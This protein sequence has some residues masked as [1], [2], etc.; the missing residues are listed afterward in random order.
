MQ[1]VKMLV[2]SLIFMSFTNPILAAPPFQILQTCMNG[3]PYNN[4]IVINELDGEGLAERSMD[5]CKDQYHRIFNGH[6]FGTLKCNQKFYLVINDKKINPELAENMSINPEIKPGTF[7]TP[8]ALWYKID[9]EEQSYLC[10]FAPIAEQGVGASYNQYYIIENA[11]N[12]D[13]KPKLYFYFLDKNITPITSK[14]L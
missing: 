13:L 14:T 7:F 3:E 2:A 10:I 1:I 4:K 6:A 12:V 11:F 5:G 9:I 8:R